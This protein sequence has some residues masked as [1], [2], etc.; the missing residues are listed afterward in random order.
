[1][2]LDP[3]LVHSGHTATV[4]PCVCV[5]VTREMRRDMEQNVV[6]HGR[7]GMRLDA[8]ALSVN[9][10]TYSHLCT[11]ALI[12]AASRCSVSRCVWT[13][14]WLS[15]LSCP[16]CSPGVAWLGPQSIAA[17]THGTNPWRGSTAAAAPDTRKPPCN[18]ILQTQNSTVLFPSATSQL[19][20]RVVR[21]DVL[22]SP[23]LGSRSP[24][25]TP[26]AIGASAPA[27][28][29]AGDPGA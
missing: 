2:V 6:R 16:C 9:L 29:R 25:M 21:A 22:V 26:V 7:A 19:G 11:H 23:V 13:C 14:V 12:C 1:M 20:A 27:T 24:A 10:G 5:C 4:P 18:S 8:Y 15:V 17:V 28:V 3:W